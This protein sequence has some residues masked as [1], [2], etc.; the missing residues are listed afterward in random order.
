MRPLG[1]LHVLYIRCYLVYLSIYLDNYPHYSKMKCTFLALENNVIHRKKEILILHQGTCQIQNLAS[2]SHSII[3]PKAL[4]TCWFHTIQSTFYSLKWQLKKLRLNWVYV[5]HCKYFD[6]TKVQVKYLQQ[7]HM[8]I[9]TT[10]F[11]ITPNGTC[12]TMSFSLLEASTK[13]I[14]CFKELSYNFKNKYDT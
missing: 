7:L 13:T 14:C 3:C 1:T 9:T 6:I 10:L 4:A 11:S 5:C 2:N 12:I 8:Q